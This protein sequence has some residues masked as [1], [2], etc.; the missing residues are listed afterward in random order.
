MALKNGSALNKVT[1]ASLVV[2]MG[3]V[4]GDLGTSPLYVFN[5]ILTSVHDSSETL[6]Y[7]VLSC[8][9]WTL[10]LQATIKYVII[11]PR[12]NNKG[13][14]GIFA[15]FAL[16][17]KKT[18]LAA[19]IT[20]VGGATLLADGVITPAITV[21]SAVE[22]LHFLNVNIP[23]IPIV[24]GIFVI[25]FFVQQFGTKFLGGT[26]GPVMAI[27]FT[28]LGIMGISNLIYYPEVLRAINPMYAIDFLSTYPKGFILLGAIFLCT[29]GA[30][31]LYTD[32]GHCGIKNIRI[33]W[34]F[35]KTALLLNYFGQA[36]WIIQHQP[37]T[38]G[39]NPFFAMM[40]EWF[41]IPGIFISTCAAVIA[42]QA[43]I[44][45]S[46]TLISEA[47]S[48]NFWPKIRVL[49]PTN[50]KGQVY[51]PLVN[52]YLFIACCFSVL[53]FKKS[54]NLEAAYGLSI[55]LAMI[56]DTL[57]LT[58]YIFTRRKDYLF[59][60]LIL[61][62]FIVI[63]GTFLIAN[64][65]KFK[66]GGWYSLL[67][68]M[69]FF[70]IMYGWYFGRKIKNKFISFVNVND[71]LE[72]FRDLKNDNTVPKIATNLVYIIKANKH[73][74][75]ESKI[76]YSIFNKQP[77]RA[78]IY[79]FL[80]INIVDQPDTF[81]YTVNHI[82]PGTLIKIDFNLG[83]KIEPR[84][85]LYFREILEDMEKTGE[86]NLVSSY[87]SLKKR[88]MHGDFL[89]VNLDRIMTRDHKLSP[90]ETFVMNLH[91]FTRLISINDIRALGLDSTSIV[92]EKVP[93]SI[94]RPIDRRIERG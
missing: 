29:T 24:L 52:W 62:V 3:I 11:I 1:I 57:L 56:M 61:T 72:L 30:E 73:D 34:A 88:G 59:G 12:A 78:D 85:N 81:T 2:T 14:G 90:W 70:L 58:N 63:E 47:V 49:H 17:K 79:W 35:V 45:G 16:T 75:V 55:T 7:G 23:V 68:G 46:N 48:L 53:F 83:F 51:I 91:E 82:I 65:Y 40:P 42:S 86:V 38:Y 20:M 67:L 74:Q 64:L 27:W 8:V 41:L 18:A 93:I 6:L 25:I 10:T 80:H 4:F 33:S 60:A 36:A 89:F 84:I 13:E 37:I 69:V 87:D 9:F 19:I 66:N 71:Y 92:E 21:T 94:E 76:I 15:L 43:L 22:G 44:S 50:I 39:R 54:T 77:K 5:A 31:A 26:F 28:M 32:M